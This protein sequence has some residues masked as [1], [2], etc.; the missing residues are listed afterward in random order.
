[1]SY[2]LQYI[3]TILGQYFSH[4]LDSTSRITFLLILANLMLIIVMFACPV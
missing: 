2:Q 4:Q 1:M 3:S